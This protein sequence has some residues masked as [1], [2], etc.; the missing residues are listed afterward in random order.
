VNVRK[1]AVISFLLAEFEGGVEGVDALPGE[2]RDVGFCNQGEQTSMLV[3]VGDDC[4]FVAEGGGR[5]LL[6]DSG[7]AGG[8]CEGLGELEGCV[9]DY[10]PAAVEHAP[11]NQFLTEG[12]GG[13]GSVLGDG[14]VPH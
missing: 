11:E 12:R 4:W 1:R 9:A 10:D 7:V 14:A 8:D 3:L 6:A 5:T 2:D 13:V